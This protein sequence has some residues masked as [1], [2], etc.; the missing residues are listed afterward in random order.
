MSSKSHADRVLEH[1][2]DFGTITSLEAIHQYG[3]TRLSATIFNLRGRGLDIDTKMI[4]VKTRH[5]STQVA[6]YSLQ[7]SVID[8]NTLWG[9]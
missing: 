1:L 8:T 5:G 2:N 3:N 6:E 4:D 7:N 9:N